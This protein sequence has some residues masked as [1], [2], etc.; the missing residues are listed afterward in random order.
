MSLG[1]VIL[2]NIVLFPFLSCFIS[3]LRDFTYIFLWEAEGWKYI[4]FNFF[5]AE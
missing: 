4:F 1:Y 2:A 5:K 3:P